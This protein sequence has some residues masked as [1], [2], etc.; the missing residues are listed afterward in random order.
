M[1]AKLSLT[2]VFGMVDGKMWHRGT[3]TAPR[4]ARLSAFRSLQVRGVDATVKCPRTQQRLVGRPAR[5][6]VFRSIPDNSARFAE[7]QAD[8]PA[9]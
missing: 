8:D 4:L 5:R 7:L 9:C 3:S 1:L 2:G 6:S